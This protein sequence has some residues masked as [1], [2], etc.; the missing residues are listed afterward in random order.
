MKV[1]A[2]IT[3]QPKGLWLAELTHPYW[4]LIERRIEVDFFSPDGGQVGYVSKSDPYAPDSTERDDL[5]SKGF[6]SDPALVEKLATTRRLESADPDQYSAIHIVGGMGA[7]VD[8]YPNEALGRLLE[9]FWTQGKVVAALCHGAITLANG[10]IDEGTGPV[11]LVAGRRVTGYSV[12]EDRDLE[13]QRGSD[14]PLIPYYPQTVLE[15]AG[16]IYECAG[17]QLPHVVQDGRL[18]SGQNQ[19]S[20][21]DYGMRLR[22]M[23]LA[24][25]L[26][27]AD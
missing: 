7:T 23:L 12:A 17:L 27:P 5:V 6:L 2:I 25:A 4:H 8:L 15:Q 1:M 20:A 21:T 24:G 9:T 26:Y 18:L 3:S 13:R 22:D 10:Q 11:S 14:R 19:E 16:G